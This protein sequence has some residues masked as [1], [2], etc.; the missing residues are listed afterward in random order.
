[1]VYRARKVLGDQKHGKNRY[2]SHTDEEEVVD[3]SNYTNI[4][5]SWE[6]F[7]NQHNSNN[8]DLYHGDRDH[9]SVSNQDEHSTLYISSER[10]ITQEISTHTD[11][12]K[13]GAYDNNN[14]EEEEEEEEE[15]ELENH[16]EEEENEFEDDED[17][18]RRHE[19]DVEYDDTAHDCA[20]DERGVGE[21]SS[22]NNNLNKS[23]YDI[24]Y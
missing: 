8:L 19:Y 16:L 1:M 13:D 14:D 12:G 15:E 17:M 11:D 4:N 23:N 21:D 5:S 2:D 7:A 6:K 18:S 9:T 3:L 22:S 20:E 24:L 10:K